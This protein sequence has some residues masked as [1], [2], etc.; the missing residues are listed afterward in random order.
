MVQDA[1]FLLENCEE[2][3]FY[4]RLGKKIKVTNQ[5]QVEDTIYLQNNCMEI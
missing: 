5:A 4:G 1:V 2:F 3:N